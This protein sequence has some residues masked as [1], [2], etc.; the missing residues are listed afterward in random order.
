MIQLFWHSIA[1]SFSSRNIN[2]HEV[3]IIELV[4]QHIKQNHTVY[5][6][7]GHFNVHFFMYE[8]AFHM[9]N[10]QASGVNIRSPL[11][12]KIL[13]ELDKELDIFNN[14]MQKVLSMCDKKLLRELKANVVH[15]VWESFKTI[16]NVDLNN[17]YDMKGRSLAIALIKLYVKAP[18]LFSKD[19]VCDMLKFLDSHFRIIPKVC[20][21]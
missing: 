8:K 21:E 20:V 1:E 10:N 15:N 19:L 16:Y 9:E 13:M 6:Q 14:Q 5:Y 4:K 7:G 17:P 18:E 3:A 2:L 11:H 12:R